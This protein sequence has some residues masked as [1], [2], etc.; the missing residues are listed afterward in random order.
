[1]QNQLIGFVHGRSYN[2]GAAAQERAS[3]FIYI[4]LSRMK[5]MPSIQDTL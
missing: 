1:M 5:M 2:A 3:Q 4:L